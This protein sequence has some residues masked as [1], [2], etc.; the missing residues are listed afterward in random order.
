M[1]VQAFA[2]TIPG[3]WTNYVF[4]K[5]LQTGITMLA[6]AGRREMDLAFRYAVTDTLRPA[7]P[8]SGNVS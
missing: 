3:A 8:I 2:V 1:Q 6:P 5:A 4:A 7:D